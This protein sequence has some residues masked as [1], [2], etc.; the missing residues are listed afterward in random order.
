MKT[1][2]GSCDVKNK[3]ITLNTELIHKPVK[4]LE[5]IVV[6]E[7]I[8]LIEPKHNKNFFKI[9][10]QVLPDWK[11]TKIKLNKLPLTSLISKKSL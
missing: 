11:I 7:L 1:K 10:S 4:M 9:I 5:Y 8:H 2:W 3:I 6:H